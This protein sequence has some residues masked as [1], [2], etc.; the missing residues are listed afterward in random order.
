MDEE[1]R[2]GVEQ[3]EKIKRLKKN[4]DV[5]ALSATPIPRTLYMSLV[6]IRPISVIETP[7]TDRLAIRTFVD[8]FE[9]EVVR[10]AILRE[11]KRG[12]QVFFVHNEVET[13][14]RM[15]ERAADDRTRKPRSA[16]ATARWRT[17]ISSR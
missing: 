4:V 15:K 12:G 11:F 9:E 8:A 14:G 5:L 7:P 1:H 16:S 3:K 10:E 6:G 13:I 2:F 17:T